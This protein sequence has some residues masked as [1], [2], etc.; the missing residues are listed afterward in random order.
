MYV[1]CCIF[2]N[3]LTHL[4]NKKVIRDFIKRIKDLNEEYIAKH[5][6]IF[7]FTSSKN[8][9]WVQKRDL[10]WEWKQ[11][12][13]FLLKEEKP[14]LWTQWIPQFCCEHPEILKKEYQSPSLLSS[15]CD[16]YLL[17]KEIKR[18]VVNGDRKMFQEKVF[19]NFIDYLNFLNSKIYEDFWS[20]SES[21]QRLIE[22]GFLLP[23]AEFWNKI[24][25]G[26]I[27]YD[28]QINGKKNG[29]LYKI[30]FLIET[31]TDNK[32]I[33]KIKEIKAG[34]TPDFTLITQ[35][36]KIG[37][38]IVRYDTPEQI[39]KIAEQEI[40]PSPKKFDPL[41]IT[42]SFSNRVKERIE[43]KRGKLK[44][45]KSQYNELWLY[46]VP[47]SEE[48][49]TEAILAKEIERYK[50]ENEQRLKFERYL[51]FFSKIYLIESKIYD[52]GRKKEYSITKASSKAKDLIRRK[53][54]NSN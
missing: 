10:F 13:L 2:K 18:D 48:A 45:K 27:P 37:I 54:Q 4:T 38:E 46:L 42:D 32:E 5:L 49:F 43:K 29:E 17:L 12:P 47:G 53:I 44:N 33:E 52:L 14:L 6:V 51:D 15:L 35:S 30:W 9:P 31:L 23:E 3:L 7:T 1:W 8:I 39:K 40:S 25:K 11:N 19:K 41:N 22:I 20:N 28:T 16:L 21:M 36:K 26:L 34:E 24:I 50:K